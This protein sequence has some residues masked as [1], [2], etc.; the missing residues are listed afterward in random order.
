MK[1]AHMFF[2]LLA[3]P[4]LSGCSSLERPLSAAALGAGGGLLGSE[5]SNGNPA[6][7]A[8]GAVGGIALS[9][10]LHA[11][12]RKGQRDAYLEGYVKGRGDSVKSLYW[13]LVA[14]QRT[15]NRP[16]RFRL[17]EVT[18]PEHVEDGVIVKPATRVLRIQ[19]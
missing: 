6:A 14:Q 4:L 5:L 15:P 8:G 19:E 1:Y 9:E 12:K 2:I 11:L 7:A 16:E 13:H 3:L 17:Y 18:I 10:G